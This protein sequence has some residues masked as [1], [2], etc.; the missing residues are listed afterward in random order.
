MGQVEDMEIFTEIVR[1]GG[2][3]HAAERLNIAPSAVSRRLKEIEARLGVQLMNRTTRQ[4]SLTE[5][6]RTF[7]AHAERI[8]A[9]VEEANNDIT[10]AG[11]Q[12][13]GT[14][15][16]AAPLSFGLTYL[17]PILAQFMGR[18]DGVVLDIDLSD[19]RV[20]LVQEGYDLALRIGNLP[21]SS[22]RG[23]R[24]ARV[25]NVLAASPDFVERHGPLDSGT[26]FDGLP[27]I[28]Y[29]QV[30]QTGTWL[31]D[32]A[33]GKE[34]RLRLKTVMMCNNGEMMRD[35]AI[36][37]LGLIRVPSFIIREPLDDGRLVPLMTDHDWGGA[38]IHLLW[39]PTRH[40]SARTRA[41]IDH[42]AD[43]IGGMF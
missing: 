4:M 17:G 19:R 16:F 38:D 23:R 5:T 7:L 32:T 36:A 33:D 9:D 21:D 1:A 3:T 24:V 43:E 39:P 28:V 15:R 29:S 2:I 42:L 31:Y 10:R 25:A 27:G 8:I 41:L 6:G 11:G 37:G 26:R 14:I 34:G 13:S 35:A 22:L 12:V 30:S 20:D 18:N 40:L